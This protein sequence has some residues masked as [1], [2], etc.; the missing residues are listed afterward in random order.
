MTCCSE[1]L[2]VR[3][4]SECLLCM[5]DVLDVGT[6]SVKVYAAAAL[7]L[8]LLQLR[9]REGPTMV[10]PPPP[11]PHRSLC[12]RAIPYIDSPSLIIH[13]TKIQA[14]SPV[15]PS[16]KTAPSRPPPAHLPPLS[17]QAVGGA[18]NHGQTQMHQ[19][20]RLSAD[21]QQLALLV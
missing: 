12:S 3:T 21:N 7:P 1:P 9:P 11:T 15:D 8:P 4:C 13:H 16:P 18:S 14:T 2:N 19:V 20:R 5:W 6:T 10:C 17:H